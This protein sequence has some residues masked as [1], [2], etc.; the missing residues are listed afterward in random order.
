M[1]FYSRSAQCYLAHVFPSI[2][3]MYG[4]NSQ[5]PIS[6]KTTFSPVWGSGMSYA[7]EVRIKKTI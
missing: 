1:G 2:L 7:I 6:L 5:C 4:E 3:A